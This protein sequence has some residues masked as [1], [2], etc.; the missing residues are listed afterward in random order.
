M[1]TALGCAGVALLTACAFRTQMNLASVIPLYLCLVVLQ[2]LTG[3]SLSSLAVVGLSAACLDFFFTPP[4][5]SLY[6]RNPGNTLAL[7]AF[8]F[9]S[10]IITR[11]VSRVRS[12]AIRANARKD[13]LDRLYRVAQD[14]L[15]TEPA[16]IVGPRLLEIFERHFGVTAICIFDGE[17]AGIE[18]TGVPDPGLADKTRDAYI[19]GTDPAWTDARVTVRCVRIGSRLRGAIGFQDLTDA[20]ETAGPLTALTAAFLDRS[21]AFHNAS[22]AAAA[23]QAEVYRSAILDALA[24]EFKTPLTTIMAAAGGLREV[25]PLEPTQAEM[26]ETIESEAGRLASLTSRLLRTAR[27][28]RED[29]RPRLELTD[30]GSMARRLAHQFAKRSPDR[31]IT[32]AEPAGSIEV[33]ADAELLRLAVS[34]LIENACKYSELGSTV[35]I[36]LQPGP[37]FAAIRVSNDGSSIPAQE[38]QRVFER[39]YRGADAKRSTSGSGLGLFVARKIAL[40]HGGMLELDPA[41]TDG[42]RVTFALRVPTASHEVHHELS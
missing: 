29:I 7:I 3:D 41:G 16:A 17:M 30:L 11:L 35:S 27:L 24:H 12:E 32:V 25:A 34:Q 13:Q 21:K 6:V 23:A 2:S 28:Q 38:Q 40:A 42:S 33:L 9:T 1:H 14:L 36:C 26:A 8:A 18:I 22:S 19:S 15:Q 39:F 37:H 4:L 31:R 20:S 10:L 5:F